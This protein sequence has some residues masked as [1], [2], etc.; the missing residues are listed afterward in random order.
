MS[1][2]ERS[3]TIDPLPSISAS[4]GTRP[5]ATSISDSSSG[6]P[7]EAHSFAVSG[8][9]SAPTRSVASPSRRKA[10]S[11]L[12]LAY[13]TRPA[14]PSRSR[15]SPTRGER[16]SVACSP[17]NG[18]VPSA[19][20]RARSSAPC[21]YVSSRR[22]GVRAELRL[23]FRSITA[24][25]RPARVTG[26]VSARTGTPV[27]Q[28]GSLSRQILR[29]SRAVS[30]SVLTPGWASVPT[31]SSWNE[32]GPVVGRIWASA[33][34]PLPSRTA[35]HR[36]RSA[37]DKSA[38]SCQSETSAC[39]H[40]RSALVRLVWRLARSARVG[41]LPSSHPRATDS[42]RARVPVPAVRGFPDPPP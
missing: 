15:P 41:T 39:R 38:R 29:S 34:Q 14:R 5:Y 19:T 23:V 20:I 8:P 6:P 4:R 9:S 7:Q 13:V 2:I 40:S 27:V 21:R 17:P 18:N 1:G 32:V 25:T 3:W 37:N 16:A 33:T 24:I 22:L 31:T 35:A 26:M 30:S 10:D 12:G 28:S 42:R 36:M 11:A